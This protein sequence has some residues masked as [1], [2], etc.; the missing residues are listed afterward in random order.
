MFMRRNEHSLY[1]EWQVKP[2]NKKHVFNNYTTATKCV[3]LALWTCITLCRRLFF[4]FFSLFFKNY[5]TLYWHV[6]YSL[7]FRIRS[8]GIY[9]FLSF[10]PDSSNVFILS[11]FLA[12]FF[13][14]IQSFITSWTAWRG[15]DKLAQRSEAS[16]WCSILGI[17]PKQLQIKRTWTSGGWHRAHFLSCWQKAVLVLVIT[18]CFTPSQPVR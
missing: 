10:F 13:L 1:C 11:S 14:S 17:E 3:H 2:V 8:K 15:E 16:W 6:F 18:W 7:S 9:I 4:F 12:S 5:W